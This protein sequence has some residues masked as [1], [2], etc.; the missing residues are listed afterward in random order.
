[1]DSFDM[2]AILYV[3]IELYWLQG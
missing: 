3:T 2:Y 1:M